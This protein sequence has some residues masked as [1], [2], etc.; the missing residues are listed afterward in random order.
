MAKT[1]TTAYEVV[2]QELDSVAKA[3]Q[4]DPGIVQILRT[5]QRLMEV[6]FPVRMDDGSITCYTGY[7]AQH[8]SALGPTRGGTRLHPEETADDIKALSFWMT[9][10]NSLAGIPSGGGKGGIVVDPSKVSR[11]ELE[12][13]CRGYVRAIFPMLGPDRDVFGPDVGATQQVMTWFLD[14]YELLCQERRPGAFT[15]KPPLLGGSQARD[16]ATGYGLV[17]SA[18]EF[19]RRHK[20]SIAGKNVAIQGFGN[21]GSFAAEAFAK[22]G[23][24][25]VAISDVYGGVRAPQGID[26]A[27][28]NAHMAATGSIKDLPG[29]EIITNAELLVTA[30]DILVP[31]ALQGQ[32]TEDNAG[33]VRARYVI[34]GANGPTTV[35]GEKILRERGVAVLPDIVCNCGGVLTSYFENVQNRSTFYWQ[36]DEVLARL[37]ELM[38]RICANVCTVAEEKNVP[39]RTASWMLALDKVIQAMRLRGWI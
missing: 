30:C 21:L 32:L 18:S 10:K 37:E 34:E 8:N 26:V 15:G 4:L 38:T 35:E 36:A 22:Q 12:R 7:R 13:V 23:A 39:M 5:P 9:L 31:A 20:Q 19:L 24:R 29:C 28:A 1:K 6:T 2:L 16:K 33:A 14:E 3:M 27:A 11:S 25:I 17:F